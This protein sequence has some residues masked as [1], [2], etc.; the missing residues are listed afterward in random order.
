[1]NKIFDIDKVYAICSQMNK[2]GRKAFV[3]QLQSEGIAVTDIE[4]YTY[5]EAPCIH[6]LYFYF[7]GKRES[8]PYF[9]LDEKTLI[10][11]QK[12][13]INYL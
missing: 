2:S 11:I 8:I 9:Q 1:M 13:A 12:I 6:H 3:K 7:E 5:N 4:C 10:A